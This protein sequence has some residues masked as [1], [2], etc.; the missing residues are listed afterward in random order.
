MSKGRNLLH[1]V[2]FEHFQIGNLA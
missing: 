1:A 2:T